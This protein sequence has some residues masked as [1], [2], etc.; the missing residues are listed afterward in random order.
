MKMVWEKFTNTDREVGL[1]IE[2]Q[3]GFFNQPQGAWK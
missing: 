3:P 2:A 1:K